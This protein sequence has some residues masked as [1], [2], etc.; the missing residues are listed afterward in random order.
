MSDVRPEAPTCEGG[1]STSVVLRAARPED[2]DFSYALHRATMRTF[3]EEIWGW[4]ESFQRAHHG[5]RF[6]AAA[7][8]IV[9][10]DGVDV[11][12]LRLEQWP[13]CLYIALIEVHPDHQGHG[14]GSEVVGGILRA[15]DQ[16]GLPVELDVLTVNE[17]ARALYRRLGFVERYRHGERDIKIRMRRDPGPR[18]KD[19]SHFPLPP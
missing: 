5:S 9:T 7:I 13:N 2:A 14:V 8:Q 3:V 1:E 18:S 15:A 11:G 16:R 6:D 19:A 4:D 12:V 17:R 10:L